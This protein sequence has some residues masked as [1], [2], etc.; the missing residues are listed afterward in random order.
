MVLR[1]VLV[2]RRDYFWLL[3]G[4]ITAALVA[5]VACMPTGAA[6]AAS[7]EAMGPDSVMS[8]SDPGTSLG[9]P[10]DGRLRGYQFAGQVLG[11]ATGSKLGQGTSAVVA[12][13]GQRLWVF[14]LR[15][16]DGTDDGGGPD[17]VT[18]TMVVDGTRIQVPLPDSY[19]NGG[20]PHSTFDT[21][22]MY[23]VASVPSTASDVAIELAAAGFAQTFSFTKMAREGTQPAVLYRGSNSWQLTQPLSSEHDLA[24][25]DPDG[26]TTNA[27]LPVKL[28][29]VTLSW[30]GP[31]TTSDVPSSPD[32]AWLVPSLSSLNYDNPGNGMCFPSLP[33]S[34]ITLTIPGT[35]PIPATVF[36]GLGTD[37]PR[38]GAF[39][40]SYGFKVPASITTATLTV[41]PG[42][43]QAMTENCAVQVTVTAQG[44]AVFP[45][46]L[47]AATT[48]PPP[49]GAVREPPPIH[50]L[51]GQAASPRSAA[52][53]SFP[54]LAVVLPAALVI[55]AGLATGR[56]VIARRRRA[57]P[58]RAPVAARTRHAGPSTPASEIPAATPAGPDAA[59]RHSSER[60][61]DVNVAASQTPPAHGSQLSPGR[62]LLIP[63]AGPAPLDDGIVEVQVLGPPRVIGWPPDAPLPGATLLELLAFLALHPGERFGADQLRSILGRGREREVD[64]ATVRRYVGELRRSLGERMPE[65]RPGSGYQA[66]NV[67]TDAGRLIESVSAARNT[68]DPE[69][70]A[71]HLSEGLSLVRGYP[72]SDSPAGTYGWAHTDTNPSALLANT[73]LSAALDLADLAI[74]AGDSDLA[75]WAVDRGLLVW[76]TEEALHERALT[77][78]NIASP[79]KL[80]QAWAQVNSR[81]AAE[82]ESPSPRLVEFWQQ[83]RNAASAPEQRG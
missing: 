35:P 80:T 24:T 63:P 12:S 26:Y 70:K 41:A 60:P 56:S 1:T 62:V 81:L 44:S 40:N 15:F 52:G 2:D 77:A 4:E 58:G 38:L 11:V 83:L 10:A 69:A 42:T 79:S 30:F 14:G 71:H 22:P 18:A 68:D 65:S 59:A 21:G 27:V 17:P 36:P 37:R 43:F 67:S 16:T 7:S 76:P 39:A 33:G 57:A 82:Q 23:W 34:D 73:I 50:T 29:G 20:N 48:T 13:G 78:A 8:I 46:D 66:T 54:V 31:D 72:F 45:L 19:R 64:P 61:A 28:T 6:F 75:A 32:Q 3:L 9:V 51:A 74:G 5:V 55:L 47:P 25:P 53:S 49:P